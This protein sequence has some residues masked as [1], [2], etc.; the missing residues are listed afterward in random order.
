MGKTILLAV[1]AIRSYSA[2]TPAARSR[3]TEEWLIMKE[4]DVLGMAGS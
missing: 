3:W 2:S 4:E 1:K